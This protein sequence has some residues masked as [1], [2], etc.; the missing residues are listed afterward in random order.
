MNTR[1]S[2][3]P[4][5]R[6]WFFRALRI[7][8]VVAVVWWLLNAT[9]LV[10]A[11]LSNSSQWPKTDFSRT[12]VDSSEIMSGGPPKDGIPA[13]DEP[14]FV[15]NP[16]ASDWVDD[17]EPVI[18][19]K[20]GDDVRAYPIQIL[21]Y[22]EIVNDTV[23]AKPL[24]VTFCPLCNASIVFDREVEGELLDFG[25]TGRLRKSDLVMYDRQTESWWQQFNGTGIIGH[26]AGTV[27][28]RYPAHIVAFA[29]F[30]RAY[31]GGRVLSRETGFHR[32]YGNN[33]YRG[34]DSITDQPFL[35]RDPVDPRLPPME[36]VLNVSIGE[37]HRLYPYTA[38]AESPI[39]NDEVEGV[40]VVVLSRHGTFSAL[41]ESDIAGSRLIASATAFDRRLDDEVLTFGFDGERI[42][43][44]ET[45]SSW[46]LLGRCVD[47]PLAGRSLQTVPSGVHFAFAWLAF[48]PESEIY[49]R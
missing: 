41:D 39:V 28:E 18:V 17:A 8:V 32:P 42:V 25:T 7:G 27:L 33:P 19:V 34:Y 44:R 48:N 22:H 13:I 24:S 1:A 15:S 6:M 49:G 45:G 31:P 11:E 2:L 9:G 30:K 40:P 43:D 5:A 3:S 16:D 23:G 47:G 21:M 20:V 14:R 38:L 4:T 37:T 29:D 26:Y 46:D 10:R 12:L 35:F 36:Y